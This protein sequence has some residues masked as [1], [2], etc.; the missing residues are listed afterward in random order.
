MKVRHI[1]L[2]SNLSILLCV[3]LTNRSYIGAHKRLSAYT[4][5]DFDLLCEIVNAAETVTF[6]PNVAT[7]VSNLSRQIA[8][9]AKAEIA[10]K[11]ADFICASI[12]EYIPSSNAVRR[13]EFIWLG[14][15]DAGLLEAVTPNKNLLT[16]DH[17]LHIAACNAGLNATNFNHIRE[18]RLGM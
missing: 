9:P 14:L 6:T 15:T 7:E 18:K 12:E 4:E 1:L 13:E 5:E 16:S 3:G 11:V 8:N 2:D 17:H 10:K